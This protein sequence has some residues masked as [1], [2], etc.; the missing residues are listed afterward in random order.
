MGIDELEHITSLR[1]FHDYTKAVGR[2]IVEG[3]LEL[4]NVLIIKRGQYSYLVERI[5]FFLLLHPCHLHFLQR[6][7]LP[8]YPSLNHVDLSKG[9]LAKLLD[10]LELAQVPLCVHPIIIISHT[11]CN[12]NCGFFTNKDFKDKNRLL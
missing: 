7:G 12:T 4:N 3:L 11:F 5:V 10:N 6:V 9:S 8:I 2:A 1:K